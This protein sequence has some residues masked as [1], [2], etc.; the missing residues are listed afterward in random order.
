VITSDGSS[1]EWIRGADIVGAEIVE[2]DYTA[3]RRQVELRLFKGGDGELR[4]SLSGPMVEKKDNGPGS[5][6]DRDR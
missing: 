4:R 2:S 6:G 5:A 3:G 1:A